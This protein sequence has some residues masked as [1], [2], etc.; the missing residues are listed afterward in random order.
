[1]AVALVAGELGLDALV[2][3]APVA[4]SGQRIVLGVLARARI[5]VRAMEGDRDDLRE[6]A[7]RLGVLVAECGRADRDDLE[8][9][10]CG[11][12]VEERHDEDRAGGRALDGL[13][14]GA[15]IAGG[16]VDL[17][18][19]A[20]RDRTPGGAGLLGHAGTQRERARSSDR[21]VGELV[22]LDQDD[23]AA[24]RRGER[25]G[26]L[27]DEPH[28]LVGVEAGRGDRILQLD[29]RQQSVHARCHRRHS[30]V[31]R[32]PTRFLHVACIEP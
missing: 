13:G 1:M 24:G 28:H 25:A 23:R 30:N 31:S 12:A 3:R 15:W 21:A 19:C 16:I 20:V 14:V 8:H 27:D 18:G 6:Q 32:C 22:A 10:D 7:Q 4:E 17:D 9:A 29:D 5:C 2:E 26:T 11:L